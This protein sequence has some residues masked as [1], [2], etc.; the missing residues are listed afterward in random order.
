M[1]I[2]VTGVYLVEYLKA[3]EFKVRKMN[4]GNKD[5]KI[6]SKKIKVPSEGRLPAIDTRDKNIFSTSSRFKVD[7]LKKTDYLYFLKIFYDKIEEFDESIEWLESVN[8]LFDTSTKFSPNIIV[9]RLKQEKDKSK[10]NECLYI[11]SL[12]ESMLIKNKTVI[13]GKVSK[14]DKESGASEFDFLSE[15]QFLTLPEKDF[16]CSIE[17]AEDK[18]SI[19]VFKAFELDTVFKVESLIDG[20]AEK[21]IYRFVNDGN[22]KEFKLTND[23]SEVSFSD[24]AG[25]DV[26]SAVVTAV[27]S[28]DNL[29]LK[30]T[31][32][33]FSGR[34][35]KTIQSISLNRLNKVVNSLKTYVS[36]HENETLFGIQD[37]PRIDLENN[38]IYVDDKSVKIFAA[39][40]NNEIIQKLLDEKIEIPY[41]QE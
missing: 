26:T 5:L 39:M 10:I 3:T 24:E 23:K 19:K 6:F 22:G 12:K 14:K 8:N 37:I 17:R 9:Y 13:F 20:Y 7:E 38:K 18:T 16:I 34:S 21:K 27:T 30:K 32:A 11:H 25:N 15:T 31:Y 29:Q 35:N 40:L 33:S 28:S 4:V 2:D 36:Q 41:Y 1:K